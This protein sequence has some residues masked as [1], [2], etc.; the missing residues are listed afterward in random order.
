[1]RLKIGRICERG[2]TKVGKSNRRACRDTYVLSPELDVACCVLPKKATTHDDFVSNLTDKSPKSFTAMRSADPLASPVATSSARRHSGGRHKSD[3]NSQ[4]PTRDALDH[5]DKV[6]TETV[7][8]AA[9][10]VPIHR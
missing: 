10:P 2:R 3:R 8:S 1:M 6:P 7:L 9:A 5:A 4:E